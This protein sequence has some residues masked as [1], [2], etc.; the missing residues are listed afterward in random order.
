MVEVGRDARDDRDAARRELVEHGLRIDLDDIA[1]AAEVVLDAVDDDAAAAAAEQS[2]VLAAKPGRVRSVRVDLGDELRVDLAGEHH[3]HDADRLGA[4]DA[5]AA[6]ELARDASR[7]S[8]D[9]ICGPPPCTT[10]GL[11]PT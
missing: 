11:T 6:L 2:G 5:V 1:D 7:S 8:I 10:T 3:P 9:E 4:G